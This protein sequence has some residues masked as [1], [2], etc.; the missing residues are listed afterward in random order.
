MDS[1]FQLIHVH[2]ADVKGMVLSSFTS[3][4]WLL[5]TVN[6]LLAANMMASFQIVAQG[7]FETIESH[8]KVWLANRQLCQSR[9]SE[10]DVD[11][12]YDDNEDFGIGGHLA[13][14]ETV[15]ESQEFQGGTTPAPIR[16]GAPRFFNSKTL[17]KL[18]NYST[19]MGFNKTQ[20]ENLLERTYT[21]KVARAAT[22]ARRRP[23]ITETH[24]EISGDTAAVAHTRSQRQRTM[25]RQ[26]TTDFAE[27]ENMREARAD[28]K[29]TS[30]MF[31][32]STGL[33]NDEVPRNDELFLVPFWLRFISRSLYV[34]FVMG[35]GI[36][37]PNFKD[38]IGFLGSFK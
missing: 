21:S 38:F 29:K 12:E 37:L 19:T 26:Y 36:S 10:S 30:T 32:F 14:L 35:I 33:A 13:A 6:I 7:V 20:N 2:L 27:L 17:A 34:A 28:L 11:F 8:L 9:E 16:S 31:K 3:P 18:K 24:E 22:L 4:V 15:Q 25:L 5:V 23:S 1:Y